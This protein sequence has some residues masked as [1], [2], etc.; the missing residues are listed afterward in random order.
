MATASGRIAKGDR[1]AHEPS[2]VPP[3]R[4]SGEHPL[5]GNATISGGEGS[6]RAAK[7][8]R[9]H[10][11]SADFRLV[12]TDTLYED[13]GTYRFLL[14]S[15]SDLL[16]RPVNWIPE[17]SA[18]PDYRVA[19]DVPLAEY[20]G[21]PE[22]RAVLGDLREKAALAF[23]ELVWLVEGRDPWEIFRDE[24][25]LGNSR[26]D[27]CSKIA[28]RKMLDRWREENCDRDTDVFIF[29]IDEHERH[30]FEAVAEDGK[31]TGIKPRLEAKGWT[32]LAPLIDYS[33]PHYSVAHAPI[34]SLGFVSQRLYALGYKHGNCGGFCI[35]A[36]FAHYQNRRRVH[37]DRF[38][39]DRMMERKVREYLGGSNKVTILADATVR[40][41]R[42]ISLDAFHERLNRSPELVFDYKPGESGCGCMVDAA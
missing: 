33:G 40:G 21:N 25:F 11:R 17:T 38:D 6:W 35:K 41:K 36:G 13:A 26:A 20:R 5:R 42:P 19:E 1:A 30:R 16:C 3:S 39:Y 31:L 4:P 34:E 24:R 18:F 12:F 2:R 29:G 28:K 22:W 14:Q 27:P 32:C 8:W 10:N 7:L 15:V 9:L 37:P 23:P